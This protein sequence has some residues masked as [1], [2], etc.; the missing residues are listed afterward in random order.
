V[1]KEGSAGVVR[2]GSHRFELKKYYEK[3]ITLIICA[4]LTAAASAF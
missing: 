4:F 3:K 2:P 1:E